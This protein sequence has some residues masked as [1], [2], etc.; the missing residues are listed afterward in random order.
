MASTLQ[1]P[2]CR[3]YGELGDHPA[4]TWGLRSSPVYAGL[5]KRGS[6]APRIWAAG[7]GKGGVGKSVVSSSLAAAIAGSGRRCAVIDADLGSA[8]LH[9][10]LGVSQPRYSLSHLLTGDV[11][12]I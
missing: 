4:A 1:M 9:T 11:A 12:S 2:A 7:G 5:P 8:N 3:R 6:G 10:L